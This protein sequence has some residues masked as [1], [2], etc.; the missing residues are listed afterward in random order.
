MQL[1]GLSRVSNNKTDYVLGKCNYSNIGKFAHTRINSKY[2]MAFH[3]R[4]LLA[5]NNLKG[6]NKEK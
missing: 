3:T 1:H 6:G 2:A 4:E 5:L